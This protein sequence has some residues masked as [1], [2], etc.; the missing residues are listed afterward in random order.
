MS[1]PL[2]CIETYFLED[3]R[4]KWLK[5][6]KPVIPK[7]NNATINHFSENVNL[8]LKMLLKMPKLLNE[9]DSLGINPNITITDVIANKNIKWSISSFLLNSN[10]YYED[11]PHEYR[12]Y[13]YKSGY[14]LQNDNIT[15]EQLKRIIEK[16][17]DNDRWKFNYIDCNPN[18]TMAIIN[19]YPDDL[20]DWWQISRNRCATIV[21]VM[22]NPDKPWDW[23][24]I[25]ENP[26]TTLEIIQKYPNKPWEISRLCYNLNASIDM[27][28]YCIQNNASYYNSYRASMSNGII[29]ADIA[30]N[31]DMPWDISGLCCNDFNRD[32]ITYITNQ[33]K[34]T[35]ILTLHIFFAN[36]DTYKTVDASSLKPIERV[37]H[38]VYLVKMIMDY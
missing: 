13:G 36:P 14:Y 33:T 32:R 24:G 20:W 22:E 12:S 31:L 21:D 38:D 35:I 28:R 23:N 11:I 29:I 17:D 15:T 10:I 2:S 25:T 5:F 26:N 9:S 1:S 30:N 19:Q 4:K 27:L 34:N 3:W 37:L 6:V 7:M 18:L 8:T 16:F